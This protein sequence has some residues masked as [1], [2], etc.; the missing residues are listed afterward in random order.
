MTEE[1]ELPSIQLERVLIVDD[2]EEVVRS[3]RAMITELFPGATIQMATTIPE[4]RRILGYQ[5]ADS[6]A[7]PTAVLPFGLV[8]CDVDNKGGKS[9]LTI[10]REVQQRKLGVLLPMSGGVG[11]DQETAAALADGHILSK[12]V[13]ESR[14]LMDA[15]QARFE[16][17]KEKGASMDRLKK[18][19]EAA[20]KMI[21]FFDTWMKKLGEDHAST[22]IDETADQEALAIVIKAQGAKF[23]TT[24]RTFLSQ[25]SPDG[26]DDQSKDDLSAIQNNLERLASELSAT[27]INLHDINNIIGGIGI[28][29]EFLQEAG[30]V[31]FSA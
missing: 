8:V 10:M 28:T 27:F 31:S 19:L 21:L 6:S 25:V 2:N 20:K 30:H 4:A 14:D 29:L 16:G 9:W 26:L 13:L 17:P 12:P 1:K 15:I 3:I 22:S 5:E 11:D 24:V 23:I 7:E 18:R